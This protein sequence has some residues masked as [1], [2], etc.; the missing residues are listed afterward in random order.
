M[1]FYYFL[2][3]PKRGVFLEPMPPQVMER[4][5]QASEGLKVAMGDNADLWQGTHA[6]GRKDG[7][8]W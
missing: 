4:L 7:R 5:T 8:I 1:L 6:D 3:G 2:G